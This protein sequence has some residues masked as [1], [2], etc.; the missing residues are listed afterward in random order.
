MEQD[1]FLRLPRFLLV[2]VAMSEQG[3]IAAEVGVRPKVRAQRFTMNLPLRY[4]IRG[5]NTWRRGETLSVSSSGVL[6]R[7]D[8]FAEPQTPLE[9]NLRMPAVNSEGAAE[10]ICRGTVVRAMAASPADSRSALAVRI[11]QYRIVRP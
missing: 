3:L 2:G 4:R 9:L 7:G 11:L 6:F 8:Y 10:V 5:E 1:Q